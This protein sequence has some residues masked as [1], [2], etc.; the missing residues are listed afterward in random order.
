MTPAEVALRHRYTVEQSWTPPRV[1][2]AICAAWAAQS[3]GKRTAE[4]SEIMM[5]VSLYLPTDSDARLAV[6]MV[7]LNASGPQTYP[8]RTLVRYRLGWS[9][10]KFSRAR[11][12]AC[13][14]IALRLNR[15][16]VP[17]VIVARRAD[18][19]LGM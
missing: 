5:W 7:G 8:L 15:Q 3:G 12:R 10:N 9:W 4:H 2:K 16:E 14:E 18:I 6:H 19:P 17:L 11:R 1:C 13:S